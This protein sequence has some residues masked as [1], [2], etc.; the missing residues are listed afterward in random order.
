MVGT[1]DKPSRHQ[2]DREAKIVDLGLAR[3]SKHTPRVSVE[4]KKGQTPEASTV[5]DRAYGN[6]D[7]CRLHR[8]LPCASNGYAEDHPRDNE[9]FGHEI[10]N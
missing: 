8:L 6:S 2:R 9:Y 5:R 10:R 1:V 3:T 7:A 4:T